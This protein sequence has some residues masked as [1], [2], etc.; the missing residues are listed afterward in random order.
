MMYKVLWIDD[1]PNEEFI[2]EAESYGL[3]IEQCLCYDDGIAWLRKNRKFCSAVILD[4]NCKITKDSNEAPNMD[5]F[6]NNIHR[7]TH[8]CSDDD[9]QI[10]WFVYT[11]GD[12]NGV[13]ALKLLPINLPW[14][15][16]GKQ[17]FNKPVERKELLESIKKFAYVS[18][19]RQ[20]I[21][22]YKDIFTAF[23]EHSKQMERL[24]KLIYQ[25][26]HKN[27]TTDASLLNEARKLLEWMVEYMKKHGLLPEYVSTLSNACYFLA[28]VSEKDY[29]LVPKYISYGFSM[30]ADATQ[31]GS[32]NSNNDTTD[33]NLIVDSLVT[34]GEVPYLIKSIVFELLNL[35]SWLK[36]LPTNPKDIDKLS[37]KIGTFKIK[38]NNK[39]SDA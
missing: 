11:A 9:G 28:K 38:D 37:M 35:L 8:L 7:V 31:N 36:T 18:D 10:P 25:G 22:D 16:N 26:I 14:M 6:K 21:E 23:E 19:V 29:N 20:I 4:V 30:C 32:H 5:A 39:P 34:Q 13:D 17:Y 33:S 24:L 2:T 27:Q 15:E 3:E 12:Y 1:I